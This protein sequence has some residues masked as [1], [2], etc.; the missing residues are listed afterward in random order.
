MKKPY[1]IFLVLLLVCALLVS[2]AACDQG[3]GEQETETEAPSAVHV[4]YVEKLKLDISSSSLK[5]EVKV[6]TYID[7]DT[8]HFYINDS[9]FEDGIIK[10][11]YLAINTPESTG[12]IEEWGKKAAQFTNEKLQNAVS[13]IV[14]SDNE[15][16]NAD[17]TGGRYLVWVWYK[18]SE[19]AD[20][21]N[22]NLEILQN[23]LAIASNSA[24]NR[25]GTECV[26]A[27]NQAKAEKLYVYSNEKDPNFPYGS[28]VE[29]TLKELRCNVSDYDNAKVAFDGVI[30]AVYDGSVFVESYDAE[31]D[32]YYGMTVYYATAGLPGQALQILSIGNHVRIVGTVTAFQG[33]W[34]VSGLTYSLMNPNNPENIALIS[35]GNSPAYT[36]TSPDTFVNGKVE[37]L[38][39][40]EEKTFNYVDLALYSSVEMKNLK[41][42]SIYTTKQGD[43]K[44]AMTLTCESE[45]GLTISVRTA[46]LRDADGNVVTEEYFRNT[47]IDVKGMI[48]LYSY[49][50]SSEYQVKIFSVDDV[51]IHP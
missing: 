43:N 48:D 20:Y 13:I 15:T 46:V 34:Q 1:R 3:G 11:R 36:I 47:T 17:S 44:G 41:V 8:T 30:I 39:G 6:K 14:E 31:T 49:E 10:A 18:P 32:M 29:L 24:Q 27:I 12:R 28:A 50:G 38:V 26:A 51:V 21:R 42:K 35:E 2:F 23:G 33:M 4:D 37:V 7:G 9:K 25:Y 5:K 40:E 16:W 22:L 45:D 19:D